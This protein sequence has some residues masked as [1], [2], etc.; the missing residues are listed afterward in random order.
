MVTLFRR[1][2]N[3]TLNQEQQT[4]IIFGPFQVLEDLQNYFIRFDVALT[5]LYG[6]KEKDTNLATLPNKKREMH[7]ILR[8]IF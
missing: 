5:N 6:G 1:A 7:T 2:R 8:I 3:L 4:L